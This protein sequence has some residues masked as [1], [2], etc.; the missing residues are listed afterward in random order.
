MTPLGFILFSMRRLLI[1]ICFVWLGSL[2]SYADIT[3]PRLISD[4]MILQRNVPLT[5][6]GWADPEENVFLEFMG[7]QYNEVADKFGKWKVQ[8]P[9]QNAGG[10]FEMK[11]QGNNLV[12]IKNI[13]IGEVWICSGQSN[14]ELPVD[15]VAVAYPGLVEHASNPDI[16]HFGVATTYRFKDEANDFESGEW[17]ET[18]PENILNFSAVG[19]FFA[20]ALYEKYQVPIGLIR[21]AVGGSPAEAWLTEE[22]LKKYPEDYQTLQKYKDNDIVDSI[23]RHDAE[24]VE[25]WNRSLDDHDAGLVADISWKEDGVDFSHWE[26]IDIPGLWTENLFKSD[27]SNQSGWINGVIWFKKEVEVSADQLGE[28]AMLVLGALVDRDEVYINGVKV[29]TTGYRYPPRRYLIEAGVLRPGKNIITVRLV[30]NSDPGGFVPDKFYGLVLGNDT[31]S[32]EGEWYYK[33]GY[34]STPLPEGQ[35]TFHYQPGGLFNAMVAP[36]KNY[37]V[38]GVIWYQGES[39]VGQAKKYKSLFQDLISDWRNHFNDLELPFLFVQLAN[40]LET[41]ELPVESEWAELREAQSAALKLP[42]TGMAVAIDVGEW[43]DI[44]PLDKETV[45]KRLA[46]AGSAIAYGEHDLIYSGPIQKDSRI[47]GDQVVISFDHTGSGLMIKEGDDKLK[48]FAV[49]GYDEVFHWAR[50]KIENDE[51]VVWHEDVP[52]PRIVRYAWSDNPVEANLYNLEGL[53]AA[54]FQIKLNR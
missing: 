19:Y 31:L 28:S 23:K 1:V 42:K 20:Q 44:H 32:L 17:L 9:P 48:G 53:P 15:R 54:P 30:S 45:G 29:G 41:S 5:I 52:Y 6:W 8:I 27:E 14:M 35:V 7:E 11:I 26:K 47:S 16:R 12:K 36:L 4:G 38:K 3:L 24:V 50:A 22:T 39:N 37:Q 40:Y 18:N 13:K 2:I 34:A 46:L 49:A 21:I 43:N 10:P 25:A 51:V 33:V